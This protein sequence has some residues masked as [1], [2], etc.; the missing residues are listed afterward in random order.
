[1]KHSFQI[2]I[3]NILAKIIVTVIFINIGIQNLMDVSSVQMEQLNAFAVKKFIQFR[4]MFRKLNVRNVKLN[5]T[6]ENAK[7]IITR[8][9]ISLRYALTVKTIII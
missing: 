5:F 7:R 8:F 4:L 9:V 2:L 1:M 3:Q 6:Q